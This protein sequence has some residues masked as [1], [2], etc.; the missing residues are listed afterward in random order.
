MKV[1]ICNCV[2]DHI[3]HTCIYIPTNMNKLMGI[4]IQ[5]CIV[6]VVHYYSTMYCM[7]R[8]IYIHIHTYIFTYIHIIYIYVYIYTYIYI[9]MLQSYAQLHVTDRCVCTCICVC[10]GSL[11]N[12]QQLNSL[13]CLTAKVSSAWNLTSV[14]FS[15][16]RTPTMSIYMHVHTNI[17]P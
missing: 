11:H 14:L 15:A 12:R 16:D 1:Y 5:N 10:I 3:T 13:Y 9:Y 7:F 6:Y 2:V 4:Y 17:F 8:Y